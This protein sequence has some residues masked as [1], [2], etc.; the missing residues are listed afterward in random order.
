MVHPM[1]SEEGIILDSNKPY[2]EMM[3]VFNAADVDIVC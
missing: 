1:Y 2:S 3:D